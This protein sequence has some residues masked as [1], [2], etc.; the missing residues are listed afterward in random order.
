MEGTILIKLYRNGISSGDYSDLNLENFEQRKKEAAEFA[1][2]RGKRMLFTVCQ[3]V[4]ICEFD[5]FCEIVTDTELTEEEI[6][7]VDEFQEALYG[8]TVLSEQKMR[9]VEENYL[10]TLLDAEVKNG[11]N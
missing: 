3:A 1:R 6:K 11:N 2:S 10:A 5:A 9:E 8:D 7:Q 4:D